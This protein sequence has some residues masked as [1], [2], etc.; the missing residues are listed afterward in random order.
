LVNPNLQD[1]ADAKKSGDRD[2]S[3]RLDLLPMTGREAKGNHVFLAVPVPSAQ[4]SNAL[5]QFLE[6]FGVI[7]HA[8]F[9]TGPRAEVPRAD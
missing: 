5:T 6:E 3:A 2:R 7:H 4:L 1:I 9:C 8:E